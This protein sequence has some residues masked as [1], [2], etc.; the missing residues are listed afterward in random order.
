M[1]AVAAGTWQ[2]TTTQANT[3]IK[4]AISVGWNHVDTA[5]D[6]CEDGSY[7]LWCLPGHSV[8][9]AVGEAIRD[10]NLER[11]QVFITTKVPGCGI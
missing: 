11:D 1:P 9:V 6:Y 4:N 8:Q 5:H 10:S 3:E 7:G 2:Y